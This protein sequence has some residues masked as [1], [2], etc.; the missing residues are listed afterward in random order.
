MPT[1]IHIPPNGTI[2]EVSAPDEDA[3]YKLIKSIMDDGY[4]ELVSS[5]IHDRM[6]CMVDED[7]S[8]K[9]L[10]FNPR[11]T[12]LIVGLIPGDYIKGH[13]VFIGRDGPD[14]SSCPLSLAEV[15]SLSLPNKWRR[16]F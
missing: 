6:A 3:A 7:G 12:S 15:L 1:F 4:I 16:S 5:T 14:L 11:A 10:T 2:N 9:G 13:A 8:R